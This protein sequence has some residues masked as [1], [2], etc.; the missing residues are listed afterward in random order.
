MRAAEWPG[1]HPRPFFQRTRGDTARKSA[2]SLAFVPTRDCTNLADALKL[3]APTASMPPVRVWAAGYLDRRRSAVLGR[4]RTANGGRRPGRPIP[5]RRRA[6]SGRQ[7]SPS[8]N[9]SICSVCRRSTARARGFRCSRPGPTACPP[10]CRPTGRF[11]EMV[12]DTG[13]GV[14][15]EP[16]DPAALAA[17]L[18]RM[19]L[20]ARFRRRVRPPGS[21]DRPPAV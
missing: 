6:R 19:I 18:K 17:A 4:N 8:C 12:D 2:T 13:G 3:L 10:C 5:V 14:L 15:C 9:R 21:T 11:P 20:D 16:N 7:R 1:P